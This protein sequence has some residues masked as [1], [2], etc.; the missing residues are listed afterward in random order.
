MPSHPQLYLPANLPS[1]NLWLWSAHAGSEDIAA[2][3]YTD[4]ADLQL[5]GQLGLSTAAARASKALFQ[6]MYNP[7]PRQPVPLTST[8]IR[9][10]LIQGMW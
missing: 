1:K 4:V 5:I 3:R 7:N 10:R 6:G 9:R 8:K 2:R